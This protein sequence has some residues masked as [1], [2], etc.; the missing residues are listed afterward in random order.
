MHRDADLDEQESDHDNPQPEFAM[1]GHHILLHGAG[2][3]TW[4][5]FVF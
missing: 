4:P 5:A 3:T 1:V 2:Q